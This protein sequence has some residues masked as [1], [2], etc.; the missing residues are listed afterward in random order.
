[1]L[2]VN[3]AHLNLDDAKELAGVAENFAA[4]KHEDNE[5][6]QVGKLSQLGAFTS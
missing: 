6:V 3:R 1:M 2:S 4:L 5:G